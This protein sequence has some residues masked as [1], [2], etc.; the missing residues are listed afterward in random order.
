MNKSVSENIRILRE[1]KGL[2]QGAVA[3]KLNITQQAYSQMEK[4]AE[5]MSVKRLRQ[6]CDVLQVDIASVVSEESK[7][8]MTNINQTGGYAAT[9]MEFHGILDEKK[10]QMIKDLFEEIEKL[11]VL[12]YRKN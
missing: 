7:I 6:L 11:K 5:S 10:E 1:L 4:N 2:S 9:K 12:L 8:I 3:D